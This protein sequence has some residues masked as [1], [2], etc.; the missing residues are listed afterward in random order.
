M[1]AVATRLHGNGSLLSMA[2]SVLGK[3]VTSPACARAQPGCRRHD[4]GNRGDT[5]A[6]VHKRVQGMWLWARRSAC[7]Y[8]W[9]CV[10]AC[11]PAAGQRVQHNCPGGCAARL[12]RPAVSSYTRWHA[13]TALSPT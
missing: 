13:Y 1:R 2:G 9:A 4:T 10:W 3:P 12:P 6:A 5:S 7:L 11:P 8:L